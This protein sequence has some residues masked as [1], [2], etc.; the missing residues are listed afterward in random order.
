MIYDLIIIGGGPAGITAG[1]YAARKALKVMFLTKDFVGQVGRTG[2]VNNWPGVP[3]ILGMNLIKQFEEHLKTF[4]VNI[5][6][7]AE[8]TK[9]NKTKDGFVVITEDNQK[10][11]A[12]TIIVSTGR[13]PRRLNVDGE[14]ALIGK[15]VSYCAIC[16]GPLFKDKAVAVIGGGNAGVEAAL[17]LSEYTKRVFI[18]EREGQLLADELLQ[19]RAEKKS[20]IQV[21]TNKKVEKIGGNNKVE[22]LT[23]ID[24][25]TN[26]EFQVGIDGVFIEIGSVP[27]VSYLHDLVK[28]ND[29][30]EV[31]VDPQTCAT[32]TQGL[33][34]AGDVND[35][36]WKQIVTAASDGCRA[37]LS[38]HE[39]LRRK[40]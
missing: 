21:H 26:K 31:I 10:L 14:K 11:S 4:D 9:I 5:K 34:A 30:C 18:F 2:E 39:Y 37:A 27:M 22:N 36:K 20:N 6:E 33:F 40:K 29:M 12:K 8:V 35:R 1:I 38:A 24:T 13:A 32:S 25:K 16:D 28:F 19:Q 17:D 3:D 23:Y 15:G 7:N